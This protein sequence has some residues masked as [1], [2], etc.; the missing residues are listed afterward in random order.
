[1]TYKTSITGPL[2]RGHFV[3]IHYNYLISKLI[4]IERIQK[5]HEFVLHDQKQPIASL[6]VG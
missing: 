6:V 3:A 5:F 1:M 2:Q 4:S